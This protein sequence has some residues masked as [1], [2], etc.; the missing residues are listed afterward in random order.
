MDTFFFWLSKLAWL[1]IAP[2]SLL[3][4]L[5]L[6]SFA[7]LYFK[8]ERAA[9]KLLGTTCV[10]LLVI[11][12]IPLHKA[13]L[14]PLD[15][16]FETNP[17]LP[18]QIDGIIVL[19]GSEDPYMSS[20]W[21]Q[22]ALGGT[23]ERILTF[24]A[25]A[26]QYP[27]AKLVFSGGTGSLSRQQYKTADVAR[28][29]FKQQGL[30]VDRITFERESR[31][32]YENVLLSK[33]L[34]QPNQGENWLLITTAW[35]MPR[36]VGIF[37]KQNWPVIPFPVDHATAPGELISLRFSLAANLRGL[38]IAMREWVGLLAYYLTGKTAKLFPT[39]CD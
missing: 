17:A 15:T 21:N 22:V 7:L 31:N 9:R 26:R 6:A 23:A 24:M 35:H 33:T 34:V 37:C 5:I 1:A 30:N 38:N 25:M 36:S 11:S 20:L 14:H 27:E 2:D 8:K 10:L 13:L 39:R 4:M 28:T 12:L 16:R 18:Q 19:S 29:L 3:L 32:T